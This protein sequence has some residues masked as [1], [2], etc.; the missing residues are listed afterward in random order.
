MHQALAEKHE[1][2]GRLKDK[3]REWEEKEERLQR[4]TQEHAEQHAATIKEL[5]VKYML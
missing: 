3:Q 1:V 2:E 5:E 4:Q